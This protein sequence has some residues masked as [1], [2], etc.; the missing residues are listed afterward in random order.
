MAQALTQTLSGFAAPQWVQQ[1]P[2]TNA[3]LL[4]LARE[5][6]LKADWPQLLGAHHQTQGKGRLGR[7]WRDVPG[8]TLMFSCGFALS[9][10]SSTPPNLQGLGPAIGICSA[11]ALQPFLFQPDRLRMKWPNDLMLDHSKCAG[12]LIELAN[13][14]D[15]TF[16]VIG[17]GM[18]LSGHATLQAELDRTI[19]DIGTSL[20]PDV[21]AAQLTSTLA[22]AWHECLHVIGAEGFTP[23]QVAHASIDY[24]ANQPVNIIDQNQIVAHGIANGLG[25]D[26][27]LT[28]QTAQGLK[29]FHAGDVSVRLKP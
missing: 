14:A 17:M 13:K 5:R 12:I 15:A 27:A 19:A 20:K 9:M 3:S 28:L 21:S 25:P 2:S 7:A 23:Y 22:N 11:L 10:A 26:G 24:L 8:Q 4:A 1:I 16:V 29:T 6:G 18:N